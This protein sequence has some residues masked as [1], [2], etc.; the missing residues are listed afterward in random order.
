MGNVISGDSIVITEC[1]SWY[2]LYVDL[3]RD[4]ENPWIIKI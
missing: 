1:L 3:I 2:N 4:L